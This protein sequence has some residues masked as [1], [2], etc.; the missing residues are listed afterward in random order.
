VTDIRATALCAL[1]SLSV[2]GA[3]SKQA[4]P[5]AESRPAAG[6]QAAQAAIP[7]G[8]AASAAAAAQEAPT[9]T[10]PVLET[11]NASNYTYV[12]VKT[13]A[14]DVWAASGEFQVAVGDRLTLA[15]EMPMQNFH[16]ETLNR[17]FPLIYFTTRI[18]REGEPLPAM[19]AMMS[20]HGRSAGPSGGASPQ[21]PQVNEP[22]QPA[23]GGTTV[24]A[25]WAGRKALAG[26]TVTVRGKVVKFNGGILGRNW[27]HLQDGTGAAADGTNDLLVTSDAAAKV[28]DIITVTGTV[29]IDKDF[30]AGYAYAVMI[31]SAKIESK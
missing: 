2:I 8:Q 30:T 5:P 20:A 9:V 29:A 22:I 25:I 31:E 19:P 4:E 7:A 17:D 27:I 23:P 10:G 1:L 18:G 16:S 12:R 26:K 28:G 6:A 15:L 13:D 3:C 11:M 24:A 21:A 14:G